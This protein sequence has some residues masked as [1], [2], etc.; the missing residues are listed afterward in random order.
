LLD[1]QHGFE[2]EGLALRDVFLK[3]DQLQVLLA[4]EVVFGH[5]YLEHAGGGLAGGSVAL[6]GKDAVIAFETLG[7]QF[8][9]GVALEADGLSGEGFGLLCGV[10]EQP[11]QDPNGN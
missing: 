4:G 11:D 3:I 2:V 5:C 7:A 8:V 1:W 9:G 10:V 6:A